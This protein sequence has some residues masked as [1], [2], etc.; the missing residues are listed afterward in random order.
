MPSDLA[1][2]NEGESAADADPA[3]SAAWT[4]DDDDDDD[5][6]GGGTSV[7]DDFT[8]GGTGEKTLLIGS[9]RN[10]WGSGARCKANLT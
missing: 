9:K 4:D 3:A 5:D 2:R 8:D 1:R 6:G 7:G 10:R